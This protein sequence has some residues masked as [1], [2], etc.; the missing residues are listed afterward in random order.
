MYNRVQQKIAQQTISGRLLVHCGL[1]AISYIPSD[2]MS[3][4]ISHPVEKGT[5]R[6]EI[7]DRYESPLTLS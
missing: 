7:P 6:R 2:L 4:I 3:E 5:V 1:A